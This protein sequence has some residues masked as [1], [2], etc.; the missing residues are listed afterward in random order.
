MRTSI[1]WLALCALCVSGCTTQL[2]VL[3]VRLENDRYRL[4][5]KCRLVEKEI[6]G[7]E[8]TVNVCTVTRVPTHAPDSNPIRPAQIQSVIDT[9]NVAWSR[10]GYEFSFDQNADYVTWHSSGLNRTPPQ[11]NDPE[12]ED[13][14][15]LGNAIALLLNPQQD[16]AVVYF[17][18]E[19]GSGW[20]WGPDTTNY[21]SMPL[22]RP[23]LYLAHEMGH[24]FG[25]VHTF[26]FDNCSA[27][28]LANTDND[29]DGMLPAVTEDDVRDTA[30]DPT[31]T[32]VS[33]PFCLNS[34]VTING[35]AFTPPLH[36]VMSYYGC[37][38]LE[39]SSDQL[40]AIKYNLRNGRSGMPILK[41][42]FP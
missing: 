37:A 10:Y 26:N 32:C 3:A 1:L 19:G 42:L 39:F 33:A 23:E 9:T 25:L 18:G 8:V 40:N 11:G 7:K 30:S 24:Y 41:P 14:R 27:V 31:T 29:L 21:V 34:T 2:P 4:D 28:T 35:V 16:K 13:Y 36:N 15:R 12:W 20:S 5:R 22:I 6:K 17:R 38:P